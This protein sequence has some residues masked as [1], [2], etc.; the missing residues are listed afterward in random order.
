[1]RDFLY[2]LGL[3]SLYNKIT[4]SGITDK[5]TKSGVAGSPWQVDLKKG[6]DLITDPG[7][8]K[9]PKNKKLPKRKK[10]LQH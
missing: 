2:Q 10:V 8:W 5:I 1:M 4:G 9:I 3:Q 6:Y 7:L